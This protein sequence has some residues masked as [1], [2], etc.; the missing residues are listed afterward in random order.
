[1]I[2]FYPKKTNKWNRKYKTGDEKLTKFCPTCMKTFIL[3]SGAVPVRDTAPAMAPAVSCF[4]HTPVVFSSSVN[5]SGMVRLSP[6]SRT[7]KPK[8]EQVIFY[9]CFKDM[10][11]VGRG[12]EPT[13]WSQ[14]NQKL[15]ETLNIQKAQIKISY[16]LILLL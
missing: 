16:N 15:H 1:M 8:V 6:I 9:V 4:H 7:L 11:R 13:Q 10:F 5:S 14:M 12:L 3:S 2:I